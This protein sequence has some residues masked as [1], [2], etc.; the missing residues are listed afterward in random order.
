MFQLGKTGK[1][2]CRKWIRFRQ[3]WRKKKIVQAS[4]Q[5]H[6]R[7]ARRTYKSVLTKKCEGR[8]FEPPLEQGF[9]QDSP[10]FSQFRGRDLGSHPTTQEVPLQAFLGDVLLKRPPPDEGLEPATL[11]LK[12]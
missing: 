9:F 11:R 12:V 5:W 6:S 3:I 10:N 4:L 7:L 8:E 1:T 2:G